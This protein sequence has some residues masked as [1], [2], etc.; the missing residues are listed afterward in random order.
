VNSGPAQ[1][2]IKSEKQ[3][4]R[5]RAGV[6]QPSAQPSARP[7]GQAGPAQHGW[8]C[9]G[10]SDGAAGRR[11]A[12]ASRGGAGNLEVGTGCAGEWLSRWLGRRGTVVTGAGRRLAC[13]E[14]AT[15]ARRGAWTRGHRRGKTAQKAHR[16]E[17][18]PNPRSTRWKE[19]W[20]RRIPARR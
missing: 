9:C 19:P 11:G 5:E 20:R 15:A 13:G 7:A 10:G 6:G 4:K 1:N 14:L 18:D 17:A 3:R 8:T 16:G 2:S 12:P